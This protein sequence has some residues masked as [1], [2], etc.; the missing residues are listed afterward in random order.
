MLLCDVYFTMEFEENLGE[1]FDG[2]KT[3]RG[4]RDIFPFHALMVLKTNKECSFMSPY[5]A[6]GKLV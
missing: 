4:L 5:I 2:K 1:L 3:G 6:V